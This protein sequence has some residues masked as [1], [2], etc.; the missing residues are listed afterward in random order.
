MTTFRSY[1]SGGSSATRA[2]TVEVAVD[3]AVD[4]L[5]LSCRELCALPLQLLAS[6][7]LQDTLL[8]LD[9]SRNRLDAL[10]PSGLGAFRALDVLNV[11]RNRLRVM[12]A[13]LPP[14]LGT[15]LALSNSLRPVARSLPLASLAALPKLTLLDLQYNAKLGGEATAAT[16]REALPG[17]IEASAAQ[18]DAT[19]LRAQLE[20]LSTPQLRGRLDRLFGV[21]THPDDVDREHVLARLRERQ[22][23]RAE[24][25]IV[26]PRPLHGASAS[27]ARYA[28]EAD[29]RASEADASEADA[30]PRVAGRRPA[31]DG[32]GGDESLLPSGGAE[33]AARESAKA[34]LAA[35]KLRRHARIFDLAFEIIAGVDAEFA[36]EYTAIAVTKQF[37]GS[38]HIDTENVAPFYGLALGDFTGGEICVESDAL[39]VT[40]VETRRRLG[41]IDGRF[42]HWVA[43][44]TGERY[45]IIYYVSSGEVVPQGPAVIGGEEVAAVS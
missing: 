4:A 33:R 21:P 27:E 39:E 44:H 34:R 12:P 6:T 20:P 43:P 19:Q 41:K 3:Q 24:G 31:L 5:T 10:P 29:P 42:P 40:Q 18:R 36:G 13:E 38:P 45:S 25:Y 28:S 23:V 22:T 26:L 17:G 7:R 37:E 2:E 16:I 30:A 1:H 14:N 11:S 35:A 15:L 9:V 8:A 32:G